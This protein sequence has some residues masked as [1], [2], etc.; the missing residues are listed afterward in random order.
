MGVS[1]WHSIANMPSSSARIGAG[2]RSYTEANSEAALVR[3]VNQSPFERR[4]SSGR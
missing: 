3:D 4:L 1:S 2:T